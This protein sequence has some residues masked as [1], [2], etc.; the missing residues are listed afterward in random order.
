MVCSSKKVTQPTAQLKP[1]YSS[2]HSMGNKQEELEATM[3]LESYKLVAVTETWWDKSPDCSSAINGYKLF[4]R[5]RWGRTGG[6]VA[7]YVK[8]WIDCEELSLKIAMNRLT[9]YGASELI[10][11]VKIGG[12]LGCSD[13][14]LVEFAVLRDMGQV[15][16]KVRTLNFRKANF[17]LFKEVV[18]RTPWETALR[19]KGAE[20][21]WRIFKDAFHRAQ[22][23]SIPMCQKSGKE[24]K[25][26]SW[27]SQDLLVKLKGKKEMHRHWKQGQVSWEEYRD[28][29]Q[30]CR[31][32]VR[33]AK[34]QLELSSARD[35]KN[36]KKG[37]FR[38]VSQKQK[39]RE[40][41]PPPMNTTGKLVTMDKEKA[42]KR[43][44]WELP[45]CQPHLCAW[46]DH[47]TDPPRSYAKAYGRQEGDSRQPARLHQ[48]KSCLTNVVAFCDRV[49][50]S[51]DKGRATDVIYLDF[52][53]AFD[54]VFHNTLLSKLERYGFDGWTVQWIRNWLDGHIQRVVVNGSMS[55]W[56]SVMSG[57]PQGSVL[58]PVLF[59]IFI[60]DTDSG[61]ECT[62]S[63]FADTTRQSGMVDMPEGWNAIQRDLD[64]LEKWVHVNFMRFS[65]AKCKVL[66]LGWGNP[67]YQYRLG[68]EG[69][70]SSP[71]EKDLRVPVDEK[72]HKPP[73]CASSPESQPYPGLHKK[74]HG[75]QVKGGDS[76]PLL[77]SGETP[78]GLLHPALEPSAQERHGPVGAC[79]EEGHKNS[80]RD[81]TPLL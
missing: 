4:R 68:D 35:A 10:G 33:K 21:S 46:E 39:V 36:S 52:C 1:L 24:G 41:V 17:Q 51:V 34:A 8:K 22:K 75:Q 62:L 13:H 15:K 78:P 16:S 9:A 23:L 6:G 70:E 63:K 64:K 19:D 57:I 60:S 43:G 76:V 42:E 49:T 58:G 81:G 69:I 47:G 32:G 25:E 40:S 2:A 27:P 7:L 56:R 65:K 29:A 38:Y 26:P 55:G 28:I 77:C 48:G 53:K 14:A 3:L 18:N 37:F 31:V 66:H 11:D 5:D 54:A 71:A 67:Q 30:L 61:I 59:N 74:K 50:T 72:L 79:L 80:Q 44:P 12:S 45:T 20:Q 73:A